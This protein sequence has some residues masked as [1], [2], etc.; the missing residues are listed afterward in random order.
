MSA[1]PYAD[2]EPTPE[3]EDLYDSIAAVRVAVEIDRKPWPVDV[4]HLTAVLAAADRTLDAMG[5]AAVSMARPEPIGY[6][7]AC[8]FSGEPWEITGDLHA[9]PEEAQTALDMPCDRLQTK[10]V[11]V[12]ELPETKA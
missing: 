2:D 4:R 6:T 8:H 3:Q 7:V 12:I 5:T 11:A 10:V 1:G 9:T